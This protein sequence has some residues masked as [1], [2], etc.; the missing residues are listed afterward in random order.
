MNTIPTVFLDTNILKFAATSLV[1]LRPRKMIVDWGHTK[2]EMVVHDLI[3]FNP[4]TRIRDRKHRKEADLVEEVAR[5]VKDGR[6]R[7]V[8]QM[9]AEFESWGLPNMMGGGRFYGAHIDQV[10][11]PIKYDR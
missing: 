4:N 6:L 10:D 7:A 1:R 2:S 8:M 11:A 5:F 3:N 9:E